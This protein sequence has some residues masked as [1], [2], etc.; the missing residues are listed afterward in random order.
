MEDLSPERWQRVKATASAAL[1]LDAADRPAYVERIC[2]GDTR[3][4]AEVL[5]LVAS[6]EAATPFF[7]QPGGGAAAGLYA[8]IGHL[9][10]YRVIRELASGG[11]GTVYLAERDDGEFRQR[12]AIKIVRGGFG[13]AFLLDRFRTERRILA[14]LEHPN[15]ARLLDGG[16]TDAGLPYVVMEFVE[17]EPIDRFCSRRALPLRD[18]LTIFLQ[19]CSAVEY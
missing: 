8:P 13:N 6:A 18:R 15:I 5:S 17:G 9:G 4:R 19:V 10:P 11:M 3:L 12:A 1:D 16:T 7:E 2:A 14:S